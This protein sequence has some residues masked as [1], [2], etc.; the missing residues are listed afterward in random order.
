VADDWSP[1]ETITGETL[2]ISE[3]KDFYFYQFTNADRDDPIKLGRW[4]GIAH[5][6]GTLMTYWI[7]KGSR[8]I[9]SHSTVRP[10]LLEERKND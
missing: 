10:L 9:V 6:I 8:Q 7:L 4:L 2:D 3:Y 1:I 5:E